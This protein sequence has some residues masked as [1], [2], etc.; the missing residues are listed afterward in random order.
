MAKRL[1]CLLVVGLLLG[2]D[3]PSDAGKKDLEK[4][5]GE[6]KAEKA[7]NDGEEAPASLVEK[8]TVTVKGESM[9][10][11]VGSARDE[12]AKIHL[13]PGKSPAAIDI[14]PTRPGRETILGIYRLEG[15]SL[16]LCWA[17]EGARPAEFASKS[18]SKHVLFVLK[19]VKK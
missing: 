8:M 2:A 4:L 14:K 12:K 11:D 18:G 10:I 9:T 19:R 3:P 15:D 16:T 13:D 6:W 7:Q 17:I 1:G 5:Q